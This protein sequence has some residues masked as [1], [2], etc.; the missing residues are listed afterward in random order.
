MKMPSLVL[1]AGVR[2]KS[3]A[4]SALMPNKA[5]PPRLVPLYSRAFSKLLPSELI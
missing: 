1:A 5:L 4:R 3:S 2:G